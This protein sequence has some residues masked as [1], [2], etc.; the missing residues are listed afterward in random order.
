MSRSQQDEDGSTLLNL[1]NINMD[2]LS[3][4]Y[5]LFRNVEKMG[6]MKTLI[7]RYKDLGYQNEKDKRERR[8]INDFFKLFESLQNLTS[9]DLSYNNPLKGKLWQRFLDKLDI[10]FEFP[11]LKTLILSGNWIDSTVPYS[12]DFFVRFLTLFPK[13]DYLD[14]TNTGLSSLV[15]GKIAYI[16]KRGNI[17]PFKNLEFINI[18]WDNPQ[19]DYYYNYYNKTTGYSTPSESSSIKTKKEDIHRFLDLLD[20]LKILQMGGNGDSFYEVIT[21]ISKNSKKIERIYVSTKDL[22]SNTYYL[23]LAFQPFLEKKDKMVIINNKEII[24][25]HPKMNPWM[26]F[27]YISFFI[28]SLFYYYYQIIL[29]ESKKDSIK[30]SK[31]DLNGKT[32]VVVWNT[33]KIGIYGILSWIIF[34]FLTRVSQRRWIS[35]RDI[36]KSYGLFVPSMVIFLLGIEQS[37]SN[38]NKREK[39][40]WIENFSILFV[41]LIFLHQIVWRKPTYGKMVKPFDFDTKLLSGLL[42]SCFLCFFLIYILMIQ[43]GVQSLSSFQIFLPNLFFLLSEFYVEERIE[44]WVIRNTAFFPLEWVSILIIS[45]VLGVMIVFFSYLERGIKTINSTHEFLSDVGTLMLK[46]MLVLFIGHWTGMFSLFTVPMFHS[47]RQILPINDS[48]PFL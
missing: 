5:T 21:Y 43:N 2:D 47:N 17:N 16:C 41:L 38:S 7:I 8:G 39:R 23:E 33:I 24:G 4:N 26:V 48:P 27:I 19:Y 36:L 9:L 22:Y 3:R 6:T 32:G 42:F 29:K 37:L 30:E 13:L 31:K 1:S 18:N 40:S 15:M 34:A 11:E 35:Q 10:N 14:L 44:K 25:V 46:I 28:V 45:F 20:N 12:V